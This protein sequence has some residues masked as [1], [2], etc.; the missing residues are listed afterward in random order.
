MAVKIGEGNVMGGK[1][2]EEVL[3]WRAHV[4]SIYRARRPGP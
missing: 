3:R 4:N 2:G 1:L